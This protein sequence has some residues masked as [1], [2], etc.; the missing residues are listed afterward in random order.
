MSEEEFRKKGETIAAADLAAAMQA[1]RDVNVVN[2]IINGDVFLDSVTVEGRVTIQDT[3]FKGKVDWS[4]STLKHV[5]RLER[6]VFEK[7]VTF[8]LTSFEQD[9][10]LEGVSLRAGPTSKGSTLGARQHSQ[11]PASSRR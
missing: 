10:L 8:I 1:N 11:E 7:E 4:Y 9:I 2:C 5:V 3:I 6:A